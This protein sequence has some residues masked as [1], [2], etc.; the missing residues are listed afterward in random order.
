MSKEDFVI[1]ML[2]VYLKCESIIETTTLL[3]H[4]I[5]EV[6]DILS[7]S[8]PSYTASSLHLSLFP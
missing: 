4:A 3:F 6:A 5:L 1:I 8:L 7:I 2:K